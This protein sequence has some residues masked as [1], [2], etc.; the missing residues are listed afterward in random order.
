MIILMHILKYKFKLIIY[1][2]ADKDKPDWR[3]LKDFL[4]KEGPIKKE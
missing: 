3:L 2:G 4:M 1:I